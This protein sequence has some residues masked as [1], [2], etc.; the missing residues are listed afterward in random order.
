MKIIISV[1]L[2]FFSVAAVAQKQRVYFPAWTFQ[3]NNTTIYGL[4]VGLWNFADGPKRTNSN[5]LRLSLVGEGI[6]VPFVP[7]DPIIDSDSELIVIKNDTAIETVNGINI[8]GTGI[9]GDYII[10]GISLGFVGHLTTKT[11]GISIAAF[12]FTQIHNGLQLAI[13]MNQCYQMRGIQ[14]GIT[15]KSKKTRGIQIGLWNCNERRKLPLINWNFRKK[16]VD[17]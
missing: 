4:S 3:Q 12:N 2:V 17:G 8:S 13:F 6:L 11:N 16:D 10:N 14:I 7:S 5:G 15:N 9:A 1:L